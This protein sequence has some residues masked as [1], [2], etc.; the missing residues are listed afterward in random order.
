MSRLP[1]RHIRLIADNGIE[2]QKTAGD[3]PGTRVSGFTSTRE[4]ASA[5]TNRTRSAISGYNDLRSGRVAGQRGGCATAKTG[6]SMRLDIHGV[7]SNSAARH[8]AQTIRS[9][10]MSL[11]TSQNQSEVLDQFGRARY[12]IGAKSTPQHLSGQHSMF[13]HS[14]PAW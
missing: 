13:V 5:S 10:R 7:T 1:A 11:R 4:E 12:I 3:R 2:L 8:C 14:R 9:P 6:G